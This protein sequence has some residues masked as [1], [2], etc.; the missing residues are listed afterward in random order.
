MS[1]EIAA[2]IVSSDGQRFYLH[3]RGPSGEIMVAKMKQDLKYAS[4]HRWSRN[5]LK[6]I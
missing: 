4:S 6:L 1:F 2:R 3:N 5:Q